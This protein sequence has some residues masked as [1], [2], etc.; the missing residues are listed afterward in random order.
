M[1]TERRPVLIYVDEVQEY[2]PD[3]AMPEREGVE[4]LRATVRRLALMGRSAR[5]DTPKSL[6]ATVCEVRN[7]S[8][9]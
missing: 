8:R 3:S 6:N 5:V 2:L 1:S 9:P 4:A 7:V